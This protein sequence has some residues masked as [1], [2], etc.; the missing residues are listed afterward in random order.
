MRLKQLLGAILL[1]IGVT[2]VAAASVSQL[3]G[4]SVNTSDNA[5]V[6]TILASG[7]FTHTEYRPTSTLMLVDLAGVSV[8]HQD[9]VV[10]PIY[11]PGVRSY[12]VL[13]YRS[14]AGAETAR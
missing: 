14:A 11:A 5:G 13:A 2:T 8:G 1:A 7:A 3:S 6:I 4:V 10:H 12:R 9:Q